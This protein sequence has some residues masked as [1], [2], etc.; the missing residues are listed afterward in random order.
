MRHLF[1]GAL[2]AASVCPLALACSSAEPSNSGSSSAALAASAA[3]GSPIV[4]AIGKRCL[5]DA[6]DSTANGTKIQLY[7]CNDTAAQAWTS[8]ANT[9]IGPGGKCLTVPQ[10][11]QKAGTAVDLNECQAGAASERWTITG[12][13]IK[14]AGGLCLDVKGGVNANG[15]AVDIAECNGTASQTW[16]VSTPVAPPAAGAFPTS[17]SFVDSIGFDSHFNYGGS[18]DTAHKAISSAL[19]AAKIR[20]VRDSGILT[21]GK[22]DDGEDRTAFYQNLCKSGVTFELSFNW[23][24][25]ADEV[26]A[27]LA[28]VDALGAAACVDFIEPTNEADGSKG[29]WASKVIAQ[30]IMLHKLVKANPKFAGATLLGPSLLSIKDMPALIAAAKAAGTTLEAISDAGNIHTGNC[31]YMPEDTTQGYDVAVQAYRAGY[32][33]KTLWV[34]EF[35]GD[36]SPSGD[37]CYTPD[38]VE[39]AYEPRVWA[40]NLELGVGRSYHYQLADMPSDP[41]FGPEG[42]VDQDGTL[43]PAGFAIEHLIAL[44][45]DPGP[46]FTTHPIT[47]SFAG[48]TT[49]LHHLVFERRD[50]SYQVL[51]WRAESVWDYTAY[52]PKKGV[53]NPKE[54]ISFPDASKVTVTAP[55]AIA[56]AEVFA[57]NH[58]CNQ[59]F[60]QLDFPERNASGVASP[61]AIDPYP[62]PS[63]APQC[64]DYVGTSLTA[65]QDTVQVPVDATIAVLDLK[66]R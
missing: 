49:D 42:I 23:N 48:D 33:T 38:V 15:T 17:D 7:A 43:K 26:T 5:D 52:N 55:W 63:G 19:T 18:Y 14:S 62:A 65:S 12:T 29:D 8:V 57:T 11:N 10:N 35:D 66:A 25:D 30:Q 21:G 54:G 28:K 41:T 16:T 50:G 59:T 34:T 44:L 56:S 47:L 3:A 24:Q 37:G 22:F 13:T 51:L 39:A 46:S 64:W 58:L 27:L 53:Y 40:H 60:K 2:V 20:H 32:P 4:S 61:Y 6:G 36:D 31:R 1:V 9:L 45:A